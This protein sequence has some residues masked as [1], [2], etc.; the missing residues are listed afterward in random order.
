MTIAQ[1][2]LFKGILFLFLIFNNL[3]GWFYKYWKCQ[4]YHQL[5]LYFCATDPVCNNYL[6]GISTWKSYISKID[7]PFWSMVLPSTFYPSKKGWPV[8]CLSHLWPLCLLHSFLLFHLLTS[9]QVATLTLSYLMLLLFLLK[10][11]QVACWFPLV[12]LP[13]KNWYLS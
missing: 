7:L 2:T 8:L 13:S 3:S 1:R 9:P 5:E 6:L 10:W 11:W 12:L 4:I